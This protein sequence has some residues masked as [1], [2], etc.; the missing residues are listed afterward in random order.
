MLRAINPQHP[1]HFV[2]SGYFVFRLQLKQA[3]PSLKTKHP[4]PQAG[5]DVDVEVASGFEPL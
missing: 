4:F 5:K 2:T 1:S 3:W